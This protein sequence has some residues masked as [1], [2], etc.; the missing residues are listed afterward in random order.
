MA[1]Y[2][3][4]FEPANGTPRWCRILF[5]VTV[6]TVSEWELTFRQIGLYPAA[7]LLPIL[8][9]LN[10]F[11]AVAWPDVLTGALLG[12]LLSWKAAD[13]WPLFSGS[14]LLCAI[15]VLVPAILLCGNRDDRLL[16]CVLGSLAFELF[17]CLREYMLFSFCVV[18][19]GSRDALDLSTAALC[20][21][22][23]LDTLLH[24]LH[25]KGKSIVSVGN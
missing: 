9:L 7:L 1:L 25:L 6:L 5:P 19:L 24:A 11:R 2:A 18:R 13:L 20:L 4:A 22:V 10:R 15:L 3:W 21:Y 16:A 8:F 17:F 14:A 12:G 23:V